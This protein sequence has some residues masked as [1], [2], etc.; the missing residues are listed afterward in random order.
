MRRALWVLI[1]LGTIPVGA[2]GAGAATLEPVGSFRDPVYVTSEPSDPDRLLVVE[3]AGRIE[4][5]DHGVTTPFLDISDRVLAGGERG[6]FSVALAPDYDSSGRLYVMYTR[7]GDG[8]LQIDEYREVG[9]AVDPATRRGLLTIDHSTFPNHNG[10]QLQIGPDG[11][12]YIATGDGGGAGDPLQNGQDRDTLLG[13]LLR[14]DPDRAAPEPPTRSRPATRSRAAQAPMRSGA[15]ASAIRGASASTGSPERLLIGDVGQDAR[16]EVDFVR[17]PA[18]GRGLNFGWNCRE[19]LIAFTTPAPQCASAGSFTDPIFD[20]GHDAGNCAITGGYVVRDPSLGDLYG[21]YLFADE[22][23][24]TIRSLVPGLPAATGERSE[25]LRVGGPSSFGEDSCGRV[26]VASLGEDQVL[27]F[28]GPTPADCPTPPVSPPPAPTLAHCGGRPATLVA[29]KRGRTRGSPNADVIVGT[30]GRDR[31]SGG[32][33]GDRICGL[34][35]RDVVRGGAGRDRL[36][37]GHGDDRCR[38]GPGSDRFRSCGRPLSPR[39]R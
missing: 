36:R 30:Q 8:D 1:M 17:G 26:Y 28:V 10:G 31:I 14:I 37:G 24:G 11:Y 33:G 34:G 25:G 7:A 4:L 32:G 5:S 6:L 2:P 3:Q 16:E 23:V 35:G 27:R 22:C 20:Y 15:T 38:G 12:L 29:A 19:G 13:K 9:A 39:A 18:A 21:R